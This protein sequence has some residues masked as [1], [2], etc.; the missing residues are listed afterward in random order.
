MPAT[1][2]LCYLA[3]GNPR[4]AIIYGANFGRDTDTIAT[5]AGA[6][7]GTLSGV[8]ALPE[9]WVAKIEKNSFGDQQQLADKL[10]TVA[11][12]KAQAESTTWNN[13][14]VQLDING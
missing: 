9:K 2:A 13:L 7:C 12:R 4:D 1:L 10:I 3:K 6:I 14:L 5:M 8:M 11:L